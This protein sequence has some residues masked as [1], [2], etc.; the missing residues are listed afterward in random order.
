[1]KSASSDERWCLD[2]RRLSGMDAFD[3]EGYDTQSRFVVD[4]VTS[5]CRSIS[6]R[7]EHVVFGVSPG[8]SYFNVALLTDLLG[9]MSGVFSRIDVVV[10]D[11]GI[12]HTYHALGAHRP[13]CGKKST[14]G[15]QR[16][17]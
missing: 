9:W 10:P 15:D 4:P 8:N 13:S 3:T 12:E 14:R 11:S 5:N 17:T 16:R 1:M 7:G 6:E 2:T